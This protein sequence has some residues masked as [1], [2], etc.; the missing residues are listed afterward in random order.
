MI[1]LAFLAPD[2]V[3]DVLAGKQPLGLAAQSALVCVTA[4]LMRCVLE[5]FVTKTR[6]KKAALKFLQKAM[7]KH[8]CPE[9]F[10]TYLLRFYGAALI[11]QRSLAVA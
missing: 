11:A 4:K 6:E 8:G 3:R 7:R 9:V 10:V 5:S 2:I 1:D